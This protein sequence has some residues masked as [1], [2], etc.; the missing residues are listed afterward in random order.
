VDWHNI[1]D[2][3][4]LR[5]KDIRPMEPTLMYEAIAASAVEVICAYSSDGR[6][7]AY[8]L[9][10]LEDPKKVFPPYDAVLLVSR[11][12]VARPGFLEALRPLLG[13]I[14]LRAMQRANAE[15][16]L[17]GHVPRRAAE[18]LRTWE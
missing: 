14:N 7:Q 9:V 12:A 15:V 2:S 8:D 18:L 1:R 5:F 4:G 16:D 11:G 17:R 13:S 6:I 3:Y 10:L